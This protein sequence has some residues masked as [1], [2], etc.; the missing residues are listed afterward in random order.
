MFS[1]R[2]RERGRHDLE[3]LVLLAATFLALNVCRSS[4]Q[5]SKNTRCSVHLGLLTTRHIVKSHPQ[6][7]SS[8][9]T[10][11]VWDSPR[12]R[13]CCAYPDVSLFG[14]LQVNIQF[15][16]LNRKG[17]EGFDLDK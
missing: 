10:A 1:L 3:S 12:V 9:L 14:D 17:M 8:Q 13:R 5:P 6:A 15:Q 11:S 4:F 7:V 16:E 2:E